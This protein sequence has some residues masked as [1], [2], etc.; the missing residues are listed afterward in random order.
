[1]ISFIAKVLLLVALVGLF[2][3]LIDFG[4]CQFQYH[5][6]IGDAGFSG[7]FGGNKQIIRPVHKSPGVL[8]PGRP[9]A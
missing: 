8:V 3:A 2:C 1:M 5:F 6:K 7:G 9:R 4:G